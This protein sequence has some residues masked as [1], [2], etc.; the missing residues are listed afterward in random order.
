MTEEEKLDH[1]TAHY[2]LPTEYKPANNDY[3]G[4]IKAQADPVKSTLLDIVQKLKIAMDEDR[5]TWEFSD[6]LRQLNGM[7]T[8]R[9]KK[10]FFNISKDKL[11]DDPVA[12]FKQ[13]VEQLQE[14]I[15]DIKNKPSSSNHQFIQI[16]SGK[17]KASLIDQAQSLINGIFQNLTKT[18]QNDLNSFIK[19]LQETV[20]ELKQSSTRLETLKH[21]KEKYREVKDN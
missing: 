2:R 14:L 1:F 20:E 21:N 3:V 6:E 17:L 12:Q 18:S 7:K 8:E 16:D 13:S 19:E 11:N 10:R 9:G 5:K 4:K 15:N